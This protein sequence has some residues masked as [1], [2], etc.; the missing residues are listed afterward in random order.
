[1]KRMSEGSSLICILLLIGGGF[2]FDSFLEDS[3]CY[4]FMFYLCVV[5]FFVESV[6]FRF[7]SFLMVDSLDY[8]PSK[9]KFYSFASSI[10]FLILI[11]IIHLKP[12]KKLQILC[13]IQIN[14]NF[15]HLLFSKNWAVEMIF[16]YIDTKKSSDLMIYIFYK[17]CEY[18]IKYV[19]LSIYLNK[20]I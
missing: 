5:Y 1:M 13:F 18:F 17:K 6:L 15:S 8:S 7:F 20:R 10:V 2:L 12:N 16:F 11:F 14:L 3:E 4:F 19:I 9:Y